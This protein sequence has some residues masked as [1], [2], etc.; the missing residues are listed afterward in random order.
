LRALLKIPDVIHSDI[1]SRWLEVP[2]S[3]RP[4]LDRSDVSSSGTND[5]KERSMTTANPS[6]AGA[7]AAEGAVRCN[8]LY[9]M[10]FCQFS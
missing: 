7:A 3:V 9:F 2:D 8:T 1:I 10:R 4:M 6:A 5:I